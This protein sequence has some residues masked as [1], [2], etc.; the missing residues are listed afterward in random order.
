MVKSI[1]NA[2]LL[3]GLDKQ[4]NATLNIIAVT[5][6]HTHVQNK[7]KKRS[8]SK[9]SLEQSGQENNCSMQAGIHQKHI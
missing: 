1:S 9:F 5:H 3:F 7:D 2:L 4:F 6:T 8:C